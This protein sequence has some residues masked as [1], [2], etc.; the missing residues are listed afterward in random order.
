M[1]RTTFPTRE[2]IDDEGK[3]WLSKDMFEY[4]NLPPTLITETFK[5]SFYKLAFQPMIEYY[6]EIRMW[7]ILSVDGVLH[8]YG[9]VPNPTLKNYKYKQM[10]KINEGIIIL[11][12]TCNRLIIC[13][14]SQSILDIIKEYNNCDMVSIG[15]CSFTQDSR[16]KEVFYNVYYVSRTTWVHLSYRGS[17]CVNVTTRSIIVNIPDG[18]RYMRGLTIVSN[19]GAIYPNGC[20]KYGVVHSDA[21]DVI[22]SG[23]NL[24]ILN[25]QN[26]LRYHNGRTVNFPNCKRLVGICGYIEPQSFMLSGVHD[27]YGI[28]YVYDVEGNVYEVTSASITRLQLPKPISIPNP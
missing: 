6:A 25:P 4:Y 17:S 1:M 19:N 20:Y 3:L 28:V 11:Y 22:G 21:L 9:I 23:I 7:V 27:R 2:F 24:V 13:S 8:T 5:N 15:E 14:A 16:F 18:I 12:S 26:V 10:F